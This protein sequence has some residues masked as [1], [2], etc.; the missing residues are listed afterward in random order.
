MSLV[1][2]GEIT[3]NLIAI[4]TT[5]HSLLVWIWLWYCFQYSCCIVDDM[6]SFGDTHELRMSLPARAKTESPAALDIDRCSF[7]LVPYYHASEE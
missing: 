1:K 2:D 6:V 4:G 5:H 7:A 3:V